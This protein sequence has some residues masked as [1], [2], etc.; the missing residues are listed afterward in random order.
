MNF[1]IWFMAK[2]VPVTTWIMMFTSLCLFV[3]AIWEKGKKSR[4]AGAMLFLALSVFL[5]VY[6]IAPFNWT[7][8]YNLG[9]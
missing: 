6:L 9:E 5:M 7:I 8:A 1:K 2:A 3:S 4:V